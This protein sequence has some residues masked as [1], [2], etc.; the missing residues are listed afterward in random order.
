MSDERFDQLLAELGDELDAREREELAAHLAIAADPV[1]PDPAVRAR[2]MQRIGR[3]R[4]PAPAPAVVPARRDRRPLL[5]AAAAAGLAALVTWAVMSPDAV[6]APAPESE[7]AAADASAEVGE[8]ESLLEEQDDEIAA[9]ERELAR[10][11][12]AL[13]VLGAARVERLDLASAAHPAAAAR[14]YWDWDE[15]SCY[16]VA[17]GLPSPAAGRRYALWLFTDADEV[18]LAGGFDAGGAEPAS[19]FAMLP[20]DMGKVVRAVV[21]EEPDPPGETPSGEAVLASRSPRKG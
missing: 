16:F 4:P 10:A 18:L 2:V 21:T 20:K 17:D 6:P 1:E 13:S 11:R 19:F 15:Y 5:A 12:E 8:L 14:V 3:A 7:T 9:L